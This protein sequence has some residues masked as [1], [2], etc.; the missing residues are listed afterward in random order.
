MA[1]GKGA[2]RGKVVD[3]GV[4]QV[5]KPAV[6][7]SFQP[8]DAATLGTRL[9]IQRRADLEVGETAGLETCATFWPMIP[10]ERNRGLCQR[11]RARSAGKS[12]WCRASLVIN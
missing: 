2:A 4:S 12:A 8:A 3:K 11:P 1:V 7:Q 6:S 5:S 10:V 9:N